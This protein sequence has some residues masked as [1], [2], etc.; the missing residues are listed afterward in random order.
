MKSFKNWSNL[1][2]LSFFICFLL[3]NSYVFGQTNSKSIL[4]KALE[5]EQKRSFELLKKNGNPPPY[6]LSYEVT[7]TISTNITSSFGAL[8]NSDTNHS[9]QLDV[10]MRVGDFKLDNTNGRGG[11]TN[12]TRLPIEDDAEAIKKFNLD[13][14]R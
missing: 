7:D 5:E 12:S 11:S 6:F 8:R 10:S 4:I 1:T 3:A 9:R 14:H 2:G 13:N